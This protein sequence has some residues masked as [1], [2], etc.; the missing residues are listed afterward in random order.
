MTSS[1]S[2]LRF[3]FGMLLA[4][5]CGARTPLGAQAENGGQEADVSLGGG[6][7]GPGGSPG[8][9]GQ[10]GYGGSVGYGGTLSAGG[11]PGSGGN[12]GG[13]AGGQGGYVQGGSPSGGSGGSGGRPP[14]G[15]SGGSGGSRASG[16][17]GSGG[18]RA[19]GGSGSGGI[20]GGGAAGTIT[21]T[22][23][24]PCG[25]DVV[26]TWNVM[27][28]CLSV[29]GPL[30]LTSLGLGCPEG[31]V[32]GTLQ[33][34]GA[35]S[36]RSDGTYVDKTTTTGKEQITLPA[37]C[38]NISGT[39]TTCTRIASL[40]VALGYETSSCGDAT[41]GG[42]TCWVSV[43][44]IGWPGIPT[45]D[46]MT[47]GK[48]GTAA[49]VLSLDNE[50]DYAY[51][52]SGSSMTLTPQGLRGTRQSVTGSVLFQNSAVPGD[53]GAPGSGGVGGSGG[54][55]G[56]STCPAL[57]S[58]EELIDDLNDGDR[59]IM[60]VS[61]R[62]GAWKDAHDDSPNAKMFPDP[63][64]G[65]VPS[66]T[67]DSCRKYAAYVSG[68]GY[69]DWGA[70]FGF[71]LGAPYDASKYMGI[72]FWARIDQG[73]SQVLRVAFPDK[74]TDVNG[75]L[76]QGNTGPNG[77]YD[78]HGQRITLTS[79]WTKYTVS[80]ASLT[81]EPWGRQA[82]FDPA[83]LYEVQFQIPSGAAAFGYWVDDIAFEW[84]HLTY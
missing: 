14:S 66:Q 33:V 73:T 49:N 41:G 9:G 78:Y 71:G 1:P 3:T 65:F 16:G 42:C 56:T 74:D 23:P 6:G 72:S 27:A 37:A 32:A 69:V 12:I 51:C 53:G 31:S 67:G 83:T 68:G 29:S 39:T 17:N 47:S 75:A 8:S 52:V 45:P 40:L 62:V 22:S 54:A 43:N 55:G 38:L 15:G 34:T 76:C 63:A 59:Y 64:T 20:G 61:G 24:A 58:D 5:G 30:D 18:T 48:Y 25:G 70:S 79:T 84:S 4:L 19:T 82:P 7:L 46:A 11:R 44:Q 35:W 36:A 13:F 26:A 28:S 60:P 21:C 80:F 50:A 2:T 77:C 81:Q 10:R 57:A